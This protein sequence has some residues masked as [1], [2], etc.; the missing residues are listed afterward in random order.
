MVIIPGRNYG[1]KLSDKVACKELRDRLGLEDAVT[2]LQR[3]F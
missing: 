2:V 3:V 1:V